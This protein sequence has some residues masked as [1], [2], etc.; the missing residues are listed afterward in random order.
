MTESIDSIARQL[1]ASSIGQPAVYQADVCP[2]LF[3]LSHPNGKFCSYRT[4]ELL[5]IY[6]FYIYKLLNSEWGKFTPIST[7]LDPAKWQP[8]SEE[9]T[10]ELQSRGHLV[11]RLLL[12]KKN[13][14]T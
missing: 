7:H 1:S 5:H 9:H 13:T 4:A 2:A 8:R 12:E 10:S 14:Q 3:W 11:C 6:C